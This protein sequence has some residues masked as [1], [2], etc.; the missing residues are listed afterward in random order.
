MN[1]IVLAQDRCVRCA[2]C[3]KVCP[4]QVFEQ[5]EYGKVDV[6]EQGMSR[7]IACGQCVA[8]CH[9]AAITLNDVNP[10]SLDR[11]ENAPLTDVQRGMLFKARRSVRVY[12]EEPLPF[13]LVREALEDA[14]YAP[15]ATNAQE[16]EWIL[17]EGRERLHDIA[18]RVVRWAGTLGGPYARV[19]AAF[20]AG[21]DPVLRGA[22]GLILA[23][24]PVSAHFAPQDCTAALTYLELSLHSRGAGTCWAGYVLAASHAGVN[25]GLPLP[26]GHIFLAGLMI[27]WPDLD[28]SRL[29]PRQP[30]RLVRIGENREQGRDQC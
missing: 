29:P 13:E 21:G 22:P 5:S 9:R 28:F 26:E 20:E 24:A 10:L 8:V 27:G 25:L 30:V 23:H 7:C 18:A 19:T 15:T 3:C 4:A 2:R 1:K 6:S 16:V 12:R 14:R 11:L 17:V